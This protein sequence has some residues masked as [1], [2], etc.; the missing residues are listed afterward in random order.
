MPQASIRTST[1]CRHGA[2]GRVTL[3]E[4]ID[5]RTGIIGTICGCLL[6]ELRI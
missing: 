1:W 2:G 4:V 6:L 5:K 3:W